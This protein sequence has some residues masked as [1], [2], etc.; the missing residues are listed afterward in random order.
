MTPV[1]ESAPGP[2]GTQ[3]KSLREA[4]GFTQ[5]ELAT[6]SGLSVHAVSALERGHRRR[7]HRETVRSLA[8]ALDL[9]SPARDALMQLARGLTERDTSNAP[10]TSAL[11]HALTP[12]VGR[13][14][15]VRALQGWLADPAARIFTLVGP[16]GV[17][18]TRLALEVARDAANA[19][20]L[21][22]VFVGLASIRDPSY[23]AS[24]IAEAFGVTDITLDDLA[25]RV[26]AACAGRPTLLLLDN[27]E[28]VLDA[29]PLIANLLGDVAPLRVLATSRAPLRIRGER[30]YVVGPLALEARPHTEGRAEETLAPAMRLFLDRVHDFDAAFQLTDANAPVI[31]AICQ[32]LD[33]LP[34][35]IELATPWLKAL[36]PVE[37]LRRLQHNVLAPPIRRR[38]LPERQ[39]TMNATIGWSYQLLEPDEQRVFRRLGALPS[40]FPIEVAAAVCSD[41]TG[42]DTLRAVAGLIERSLL[43]RTEGA[44]A[45]GTLYVMLE[46]VHA[47]A[48]AEL[49]SSGERDLAMEGLARY[50]VATAVTAEDGL[51]GPAQAEWLDRV[52]D[53]LE[54]FRS[55]LSWLIEHDRHTEACAIVW[56]LLFFWLIRGHTTEGLGWYD[57]LLGR[58]SLTPPDRAMAMAGAAVMRYA[59]GD[60]DGARRAAT[61]ALAVS[62]DT[63]M[64]AATTENILGHIGIAVGDLAAAREHFTAAV[65]RF[66]TLGVPWVT[67]NALAGLASV[68]LA[69]GDF[70]RT[71]RLLADARTEMAGVGPWFSEIVLYVQAVLSVRRGKPLEAIAV[72]RES[73]SHIQRLHDKFALVYSLIPL[74]AAAEMIGDDA[75]AARVLAARDAVTERTGAIPVDDSVRDLRERVEQDARARLGPRRWAREY[76]AGRHASVESLLT[77]ID[78][79]SK[80]AIAAT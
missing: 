26:R 25:R 10:D 46:T 34:L 9:P 68:S 3:L 76:E 47:Y 52:R 56:Q 30:E 29:V 62:S 1:K 61:L 50:C 28:H 40:R 73:L 4:A 12:L 78:E 18:K 5:E 65:E 70:E 15:D 33:A 2:F 19:H 13:E 16:G 32:R 55:G 51:R 72:V 27:V 71:S 66:G 77:D 38:D 36:P 41:A 48:T 7:P 59:Q 67:G 24:A 57:R 53:D 44:A 42:G 17:G 54:S 6:I 63:S 74:A 11:P 58:P 43:L 23:V 35:A 64:A 45:S 60:L 21:R 39:Q 20:G 31:A 79:R 8:L 75:W 69:A 22:V 49:T 80:R 14:G 37:L